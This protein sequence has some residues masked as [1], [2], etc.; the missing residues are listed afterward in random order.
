M[1][2]QANTIQKTL[3]VLNM[4]CA[5]CAKTV[6]DTIKNL[7]GV[8]KVNAHIVSSYITVEY[9]AEK[10]SLQHIREAVRSK[11]Y[12][13]LIEENTLSETFEAIHTHE[14][15]KLK[16]RTIWAIVLSLPVV[17]L[18][19]FFMNVP[20]ANEWM[21]LL[22]TPVTFGLGRHFFIRAWKQLRHRS[23]S[24]D[25]L[26][27]LSTG[28]AYLF[29]VFNILFP[30]FWLSKGIHPHV[31]FE[32]ASVIITFVL[33]GRCIEEKAKS[34]ISLSIK[35]LTGLQ[36]K[37]VTIV[38]SD[39]QLTEQFAE[40]VAV[41]DILMVR[42]GEKIAVDG[43]VIAGNSYVDQSMLN[44]EPVAVL[45]QEKDKV[46][47]GTVNQKGSF[48]FKAEKTGNETM[49]AQII[50]MVQDAQQSKAPVQKLA[51]TVAGIFVPVVISIAAIAFISWILFDQNTGFTHGL[52][53]FVTV[54][55]IACPCALGLATPAAIMVGIGK[56]AEQGILVKNAQSLEMAK[57]IDAIV[58]DKTGTITEGKP[59]VS[60]IRWL[61]NDKSKDSVLR[62]LEEQSEHPLANA[63]VHFLSEYPQCHL[64]DFE[65]ITGKGV[66]GTAD[67]QTYFVGNAKLLAENQIHIDDQLA[68]EAKKL[69]EQALITVWFADS[70][71]ALAFIV[72]E[73]KIKATSYNAIERLRNAGISV[74]MLTGDSIDTA[75][76]VAARIGTDCFHAEMLPQEKADFIAQLQAEG[77]T[78]A[79]VGDG[80][81]DSAA[82]AQANVSIAMGKGSDIAIQVAEMTIVSSDLSKIPTA[83]KLSKQ[84]VAII[85]QNLVWAFAYNLIGIPIAA[86]ALY[87]LNGFLLNPMIAGGAMA[88]SSLSVVCNSLRLRLF[89]GQV[90]DAN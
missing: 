62:S 65:S 35:K 61:D 39:G 6:E 67:G 52:T 5:A 55:I 45:K 23:A 46:Y 8:I 89:S 81:N 48:R 1:K 58:F 2:K 32:T 27:A 14:Y 11:G 75:T 12:D 3:P 54:L 34:N 51:D 28:I 70:R 50:R 60:T 42:P 79:M 24:M 68:S 90:K 71:Q 44:G 7:S 63:I 82:L 40:Q 10:I 37:T 80:I 59:E 22:A 84:T 21:W 16:K 73:D 4:H 88:L 33:S 25:T 87:V 43:I 77:K 26:V 31:Y 17:A 30:D 85:R 9:H 64:T 53:A 78:V 66:K 83:I 69:N 38:Q 19:M 15:L 36:P 18:S 13:L 72:I 57:K 86:G 74:Y 20:F 76:A 49:L 56:A 47:A 29:S 41:G